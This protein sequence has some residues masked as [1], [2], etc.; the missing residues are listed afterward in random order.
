[1]AHSMTEKNGR[2]MVVRDENDVILAQ[3]W[4]WREKDLICFDDV[5][6]GKSKPFIHNMEKRYGTFD[7]F[8]DQVLQVY[9]QGV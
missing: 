5:E 2:V 9:R 8:T 3:S 1:M 6:F 7:K 4:V